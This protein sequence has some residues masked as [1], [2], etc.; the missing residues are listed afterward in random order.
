[1]VNGEVLWVDRFGN[2][3]LNIA[4]EQLLELG[5]QPGAGLEVRMG[6]TGAPRALGRTRSPTPSRRSSC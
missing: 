2:C 3:Q 6:E 5:A 4:P 1:M